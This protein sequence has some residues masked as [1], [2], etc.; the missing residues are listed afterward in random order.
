[1]LD[2]HQKYCK[3]MGFI[4]WLG[5]L[6]L[7]QVNV[8]AATGDSQFVY[9]GQKW[10]EAERKAYYS[11]DQGS[12][13]MPLKWFQ[14]LKQSNGE[15]FLADSLKRYGYLANPASPTPGLPVGFTVTKDGSHV[16]MTCS[17]CHV[18]EI[19][20]DK[21]LYR[22]DGGPAIVDFQSFATDL[23][24]AVKSVLNDPKQFDEFAKQVLGNAATADKQATLRKQVE[25]WDLPYR[26]IMDNALPKDKPWGPA[27]LDA[28]GMIFNRVTGLDIGTSADHIIA[29]N[30]HL[31]DAPVR[32]PFVWNAPIQDKTQWP[33][34]ADNGNSI[35]GL[36]RNLGE[37]IGVFAHFNPQK[38]D[39]RVL[40]IDY[41]SENSANFDGLKAQEVHLKNIGPPQWPWKQGPYAI[42]LPLAA[43]GKTIFE[44]TTK[45]EEG[46]CAA[47]HGIR[48][49]SPRGK[50]QTWATPLCDVQT[51]QRQFNL[52]SWQVDTGVLAGAQIP[53]LDKPLKAEKELAFNVLGIS[54]MGSVL[55]HET[56]TVVALESAAKKEALKLESLLGAEKTQKIQEKAAALRKLQGNLITE[57]TSVL[58]GAFQTLSH[59]EP[60]PG[61]STPTCKDSFKSASPKLA[62]ESRV[63]QGIWATA[64]YLHN[65]SIPTLTD[66]L[67]PVAN[68]STAF[69]V[70]QAYDPIKV[71]LA[72][73][74]SQ[75]NYTYQT[76]D[77]KEITSG[78]SRCGHEFGTQLNAAD[79]KALLEYLKQL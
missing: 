60:A 4:L 62:F 2:F 3:N 46:G 1:M 39:W 26:T 76:T 5:S 9:Q 38:D 73:E 79:K 49:G 69:K 35:L 50:E 7:P 75:F 6:F 58:Q 72:S 77:C 8:M 74:Q 78:N 42:N 66:L 40:G 55:Q 27:R 65:G 19:S 61:A 32:Y 37:V 29:S 70:G 36:S 68:R 53:F 28:V 16:G 63:L 24:I 59:A 18:R 17:A 12:Q 20:V 54:V 13:L 15:L 51:D 64:P 43:Q 34:F 67:E 57:Q 21:Q 33:G 22:I 31:A 41:L 25:D 56:S 10:T 11:Q 45:T 44:S 14:S 48:K 23:G 47:C 71:G 30:I 52:L